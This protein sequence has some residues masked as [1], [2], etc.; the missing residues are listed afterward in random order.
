[1]DQYC[2]DSSPQPWIRKQSLVL[3]VALTESDLRGHT[4]LKAYLHC[5]RLSPDPHC[6]WC[7]TGNYRSIIEHFLVHCPRYYSHPWTSPPL[8]CLPS[9]QT[10]VIR[11]TGVFLKKQVSSFFFYITRLWQPHRTIGLIWSI[12]NWIVAALNNTKIKTNSRVTTLA[13]FF[14]KVLASLT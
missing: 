2:R 5:L 1:M 10:A 11:F 13:F 14:P 3:D 7:R 12:I 9:R 4:T 8:T 6:S